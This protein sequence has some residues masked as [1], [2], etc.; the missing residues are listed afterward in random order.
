MT[1]PLTD[2]INALTRYANEVTGASDTTLSDA[3]ET[4]VEGY[5]QGGGGSVSQDFD[6]YLSGENIEIRSNVT[7]VRTGG[8]TAH[9]GITV[10]DLPEC[11]RLEN[12]A[13][14][15]S[16]YTNNSV[17]FRSLNRLNLPKVEALGTISL[18]GIADGGTGTLDSIVLPS[19]KQKLWTAGNGR[20]FQENTAIKKYDFGNYGISTP[21]NWGSGM[22]F[23]ST[24][25]AIE[26]IIFRYNCV[27]NIGG[28]AVFRKNN[29]TNIALGTNC[30]IYVP[31]SQIENYKVATNWSTLYAQYPDMFKTIEGSQYEHYYADGTPI[32]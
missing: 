12:G 10:I 5:G 11:T 22:D 2:A 7:R 31:S 18:C 9:S 3:V 25:D 19:L 29:T 32:E 20:A 23:Y 6:Q 15:P 28:T 17:H 27:I 4:L 30:F 14:Q 24:Q 26:A 1:Q 8:I 16:T 13:I 21:F